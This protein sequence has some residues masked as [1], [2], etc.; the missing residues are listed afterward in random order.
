MKLNTSLFQS[1]YDYSLSQYVFYT[2]HYCIELY[3]NTN[4]HK[5]ALS[6]NEKIYYLSQVLSH[7]CRN[8]S[9]NEVF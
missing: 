3:Q 2:Y 8:E 4:S 6:L 7:A 1:F 9:P 5:S